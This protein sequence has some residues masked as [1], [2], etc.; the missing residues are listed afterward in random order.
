MLFAYRY[1]RKLQLVINYIVLKFKLLLHFKVVHNLVT[2][3]KCTVL[4]HKR[5]SHKYINRSEIIQFEGC[6]LILNSACCS[7]S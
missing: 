6:F 7:F 4:S 3:A 2:R 5:S 1:V